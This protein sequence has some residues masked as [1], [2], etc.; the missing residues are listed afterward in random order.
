MTIIAGATNSPWI[1]N[2]A[3]VRVLHKHFKNPLVLFRKCYTVNTVICLF[4]L[5]NPCQDE[6]RKNVL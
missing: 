1:K 4:L 6:V 2:L 5:R 3:D